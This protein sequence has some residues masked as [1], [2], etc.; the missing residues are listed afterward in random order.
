MILHIFDWLISTT[1]SIQTTAVECG[2]DQTENTE[3]ALERTMLLAILL[4]VFDLEVW[5]VTAFALGN[6]STLVTLLLLILFGILEVSL[7][8]R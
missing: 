5:I 1:S 7:L 8:G 3:T 2:F 6:S 4:L